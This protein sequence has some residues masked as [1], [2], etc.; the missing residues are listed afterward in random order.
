M[1]E[2]LKQALV[3]LEFTQQV[4]EAGRSPDTHWE[5]LR[6]LRREAIAKQD[7]AIASL[8]ASL[9]A[10]DTTGRVEVGA[11]P[12]PQPVLLEYHEIAAIVAAVKAKYPGQHDEVAQYAADRAQR[13]V[14][15][16]TA[17]VAL[18]Q[19]PKEKNDAS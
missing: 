3:A 4:D 7:A 11:V 19:T 1:N 5:S 8:Q 16:R 14:L 12:V 2:T 9:A 15:A 18:P 17:G 10:P 13:A 6:H